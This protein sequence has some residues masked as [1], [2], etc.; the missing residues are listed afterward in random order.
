MEPTTK[1]SICKCALI[2]FLHTHPCLSALFFA[3]ACCTRSI[4]D[5]CRGL[6]RGC[7]LCSSGP[8]EKRVRT[9]YQTAYSSSAEMQ[10]VETIRC[11]RPVAGTLISRTYRDEGADQVQLLGNVT[12]ALAH[13][14]YWWMPLLAQNFIRA[15]SASVCGMGATGRRR[16]IH[17]GYGGRPLNSNNFRCRV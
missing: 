11:K 9:K 14:S 13:G 5:G 2:V 1:G 16:S 7:R 3:G 8:V 6:R 17:L 4:L 15:T 10:I 12:F